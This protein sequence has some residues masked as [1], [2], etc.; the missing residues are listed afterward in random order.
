[1]RAWPIISAR[2]RI[3]PLCL[4]PCASSCLVLSC[5]FLYISL[6]LPLPLSPLSIFSRGRRGR[7]RGAAREAERARG[8]LECVGG[9]GASLATVVIREYILL[10]LCPGRGPEEREE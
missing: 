9:G 10:L 3:Q 8:A 6:P 2:A 4:P 7:G 1:M 5:L